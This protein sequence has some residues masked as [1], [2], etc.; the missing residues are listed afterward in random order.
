M[1]DD[2]DSILS[3]LGAL[4]SNKK[5]TTV[6]FII[7]GNDISDS[8]NT[9]NWKIEYVSSINRIIAAGF[10]PI[11]IGPQPTNNGAWTAT[12]KSKWID[13]YAWTKAYCPS[14]G[15]DYLSLDI[16]IEDQVN[17]LMY[18]EYWATE[19]DSVHM[20][21]VGYVTLAEKIDELL[22]RAMPS[23]TY[24]I[25]AIKNLPNKH[26]LTVDDMNNI[27]LMFD[28]IGAEAAN[29]RG[30]WFPTSDISANGNAV[31]SLVA[32]YTKGTLIG[33]PTFANGGI[34]M[35]DVSTRF[36][37]NVSVGL[38]A[39]IGCLNIFDTDPIFFSNPTT[40]NYFGT[41]SAGFGFVTARLVFTASEVSSFRFSSWSWGAIDTV[42]TVDRNFGKNKVL[43]WKYNLPTGLNP[44]TVAN[45]YA[46]DSLSSSMNYAYIDGSV[47]GPLVSANNVFKADVSNPSGVVTFNAQTSGG[48]LVNALNAVWRVM[49]I[50]NGSLNAATM[51]AAI[52]RFK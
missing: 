40:Y 27:K 12:Q 43:H 42:P 14:I 9:E 6:L 20:N 31:T 47:L 39:D 49:Y 2:L 44:A 22:S 46:G 51:S 13:L 24:A 41:P 37:T 50:G 18:E 28:D 30:L 29:L 16:F 38:N 25:N 45:S 34:R 7:G 10:R 3:D 21:S 19:L 11:C 36:L 8:L 33:S 48:A 35:N 23:V 1:Q 4:P 5:P 17:G 52:Q 15:V 32:P 26:K